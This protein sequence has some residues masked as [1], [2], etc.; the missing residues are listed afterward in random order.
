MSWPLVYLTLNAI[1]D[2]V[3]HLYFVPPISTRTC[4]LAVMS[5]RAVVG[6]PPLSGP[7]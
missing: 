4:P 3:T 6:R 7:V 2:K 1:P 5:M